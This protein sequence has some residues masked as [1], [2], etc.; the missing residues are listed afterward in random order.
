MTSKS[1]PKRQASKKKLPANKPAPAK[2]PRK[3]KRTAKSKAKAS[4]SPTPRKRAKRTRSGAASSAAIGLVS[5]SEFVSRAPVGPSRSRKE[6]KG[7]TVYLEPAQKEMLDRIAAQHTMT[8]QDLGLEAFGL[9][10]EQYAKAK[11]G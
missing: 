8:L 10:F 3:T 7:V 5:G 6:R 1:A 11:P 4:A 9:L 2:Q